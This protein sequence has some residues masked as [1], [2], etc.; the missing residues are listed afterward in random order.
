MTL[1]DRVKNI[2]LTPKTEW[3]KIAEE[4]AT[5]QSI[6]VNYV[7]I[8]AAIGPIAMAIAIV[9]FGAML[10]IGAAIVSYVIALV[11]VVILTWIADAL[12]PSFGG[13]KNF[14]QAL[15]LV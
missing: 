14:V 9:A 1:V 7:A 8:L 6:F 13:E 3:P 5:T 4:T 11:S 10:G 2:L 12:A 15:K